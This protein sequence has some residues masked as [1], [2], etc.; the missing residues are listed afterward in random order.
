MEVDSRQIKKLDCTY[1]Y[2]IPILIGLYRNRISSVIGYS[3]VELPDLTPILILMF[4]IKF[5]SEACL[6]GPTS[7]NY[8]AFLVFLQL[9]PPTGSGLESCCLGRFRQ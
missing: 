6:F 8:N 9:N 7:S 3:E 1:I 5:L 2:F 4:L